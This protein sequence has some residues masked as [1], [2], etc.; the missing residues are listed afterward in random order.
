MANQ[1]LDVVRRSSGRRAAD[2]EDDLRELL[3]PDPG[4]L[5]PYT[6]YLRA[7]FDLQEPALDEPDRA[8][9][10]TGLELAPFQRDGYERARAICRRHGGVVYADGVGTGRP[11]RLGVH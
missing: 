10:P 7:L 6:I 1:A 5:D 3:F 8:T 11:D 9:R 2:Y 4:L